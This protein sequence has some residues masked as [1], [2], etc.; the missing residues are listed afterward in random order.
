MMTNLAGVLDTGNAWFTIVID[1]S[2]GWF[3][4]EIDVI[5]NSCGW[6]TGDIDTW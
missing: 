6:F 1:D 3:T 5:E 4:G 2:C